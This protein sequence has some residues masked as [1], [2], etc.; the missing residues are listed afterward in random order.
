M[1]ASMNSPYTPPRAEVSNQ[2]TRDLGQWVLY[3]CFGSVVVFA[4]LV[5][6]CVFAVNTGKRHMDPVCI[7]YLQL[8]EGQKYDEA[9]S[10][11]GEDGR[12]ALPID[13]HR[14][15]VSGVLDKL[16]AIKKF[17]Y[18]SVFSGVDQKGHWGRLAYLTEFDK[19]S[20]IVTLTLRDYSGTYKIDGI[21]FNSPELTNF[22]NQS[23]SKNP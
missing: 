20:G 12:K 16:G 10:L 18:Q 2:K 22:I 11:W 7:Q 17:E 23:I 4:L 9:Y 6:S 14:A 1:D 21:N 5:A 8:I 19:G 13:K 3:G 15:F